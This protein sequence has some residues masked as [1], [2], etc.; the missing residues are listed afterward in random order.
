MKG[1]LQ[2]QQGYID[3]VWAIQN[4]LIIKKINRMTYQLK[5]KLFI[6]SSL[7]VIIFFLPLLIK[8][9]F[10]KRIFQFLILSILSF[11]LL[12]FIQEKIK[13]K[14]SVNYVGLILVALYGVGLYLLLQK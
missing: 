5:V 11:L 4:K 3:N 13:M 2:H 14:Q 8:T 7:I 6:F 12:S 9:V 1:V 10:I